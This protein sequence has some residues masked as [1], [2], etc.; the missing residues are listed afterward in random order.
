[1]PEMVDL[2][3]ILHLFIGKVASPHSQRLDVRREKHVFDYE[4]ALDVLTCRR[5]VRLGKMTHINPLGIWS[6]GLFTGA[7]A[8]RTMSSADGVAGMNRQE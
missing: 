7:S 8:F 6:S 1:M 2:R 4:H 3:S 5:S